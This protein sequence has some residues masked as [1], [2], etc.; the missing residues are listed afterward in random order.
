[1]TAKELEALVGKLSEAVWQAG[2]EDVHQVR[3]HPDDCPTEGPW[4]IETDFHVLTVQRDP[5]VPR[6]QVLLMPT[7]GEPVDLH[8]SEIR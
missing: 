6:G 8:S 2:G 1:M 4:T 5:L 3:V 7:P